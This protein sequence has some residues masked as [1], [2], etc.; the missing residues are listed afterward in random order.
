MRELSDP[1]LAGLL[2]G[3]PDAVVC[4]DAS[5]RIVLANAQAE[6]LFGYGRAEL[7]GQ[8]VEILVPDAARAGHEAKRARYAATPVPRPMGTGLELTGRRHDGRTFPAEISLA[9]IG[10]EEGLVVM[11]AV[12]DVTERRA[13]E[14]ERDRLRT[15]AERDRLESL[16]NLAGG[17]AHDFNNLMGIISSYAAFIREEA[18]RER[19]AD[20][21]AVGEDVQQIEKAVR[22]AAELTRQLLSFGRREVTQPQILDLNEVIGG[23]EP[24]LASTLGGQAELVT[25]YAARLWPV[26]ADPG[27]VERVLVSL[28][29]N[30]RDA[31]P[32]GGTLTIRTGGTE[33]S[34]AGDASLD[35][36]APGRYASVQVSDTGTG[37]PAEVAARAFEPFFTTKAAGAGPGLGLPTVYGIITQAAGHVEIRSEVGS[38]TTVEVLLPASAQAAARGSG[39]PV[40]LI[41]EDEAALREAARRMLARHGYQVITAASGA[42]A[43]KAAAAAPAA[44]D[45]LL[46]DVVM[47][48]MLGPQA[49]EQ[50]RAFHPSVKVVFMS[51]Y[52]RGGLDT[53]GVLD[54]GVSLIQKPFTE[55]ALLAKIGEVLPGARTASPPESSARVPRQTGKA[56]PARQP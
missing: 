2:D 54:E 13:L 37:M 15:Q 55:A 51:G 26:L 18:A 14:A 6:H 29:A 19:A 21:Q 12:R 9:S 11:A 20:W 24:L 46:T 10:T 35:G 27:Q 5:G 16:G 45:L 4:V 44:I 33:V 1:L 34:A 47:P 40:V 49:A 39:A 28:A 43:V 8:P 17:I 32:G 42:E 23:L 48:Q 7:A 3:A 53:Q 50:V 41:V 36:L 38:G 52:T 31:M 22:R 30:A 25:E 56:A